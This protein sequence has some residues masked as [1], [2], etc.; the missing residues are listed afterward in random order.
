MNEHREVVETGPTTTEVVT[1]PAASAA[2]DQVR[3]T[4][5][6]P[7]SAR[8]QGSYRLVQAVYL[9]FGLIEA[10]LAIRFVLRLFGA[11]PDAGFAQLIYGASGLFVAPFLGLFGTPQSGANALELHTIVALAVYP[12]LGWLVAKLVWLAF[13]ESRSATVTT[14][15]SERTRVS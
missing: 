5:Y 6:D 7:F 11:N 3:A 8:R 2:V 10:L 13:G 9:I 14:A 1:T 15:D 4:S 12:L